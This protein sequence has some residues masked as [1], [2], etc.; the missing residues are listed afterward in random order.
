VQEAVL[1]ERRAAG[2]L[3]PI[4]EMGVQDGRDAGQS[5]PHVHVH[6]IPRE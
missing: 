1:R 3:E 4:I 2:A 6:L 5:V